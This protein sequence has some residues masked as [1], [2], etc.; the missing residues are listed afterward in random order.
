MEIR[1]D[2]L[3]E[4][5]TTPRE[6]ADL[7][8]ALRSSVERMPKVDSVRGVL[9]D[10]VPDQAKRAAKGPATAFG[11]FLMGL[12]VGAISAVF[13]LI[14]TIVARPGQ[15]PVKIKIT[16]NSTEVSF[17]PRSISPECLAALAAQLSG[18]TGVAARRQRPK[19]Q[20]A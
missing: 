9:P 15:P 4:G 20:G 7:S 6:I 3:P 5:N 12:P 1:I 16:A 17:D 2:I 10:T 19:R 8:Q 14:K 18:R 13:Q 11:S